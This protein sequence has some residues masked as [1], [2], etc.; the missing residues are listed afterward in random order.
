MRATGQ[1][2]C[3]ELARAASLENGECG[4]RPACIGEKQRSSIIINN[5]PLIFTRTLF[6]PRARDMRVGPIFRMQ[7]D[8]LIF[9]TGATG[10]V[11][12][13]L[14][15]ELLR[16]QPG[17][18]LALLIRPGKRQVCRRARDRNRSSRREG[19]RSGRRRRR[20]QPNCGLEPAA[21]D[22]LAAETTRV[23][24]SAATVRF[25]HSLSEARSMNV[26]GTRRVL[27]FA[28]KAPR[29]SQLLVCGHRL[30]RG[31][32]HRPDTRRRA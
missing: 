1:W 30:C 20:N 2:T 3:I 9:L 28:G 10:F 6:S 29:N 16:T 11:G 17:A 21:Y 13:R 25:D 24:H 12:T 32:A 8:E 14:V 26:E 5:S 19:A 4:R 23:I 15:Q 27:D 31:P 7:N 22:L 18:R